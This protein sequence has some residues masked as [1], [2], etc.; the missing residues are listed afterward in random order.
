[1]QYPLQTQQA[2]IAKHGGCGSSKWIVVCTGTSEVR[3]MELLVISFTMLCIN[4]FLEPTVFSSSVTE[5]SSPSAC[6]K[7][8]CFH[9]DVFPGDQWMFIMLISLSHHWS[10][11]INQGIMSIPKIAPHG[12]RGHSSSAPCARGGQ[13]WDRW[14]QSPVAEAREKRWK[15]IWILAESQCT[16][17]EHNL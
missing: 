1:M 4:P 7:R 6:G 12:C 8:N 5:A 14:L 16:W 9:C 17:K 15:H 11:G 13:A 10:L 2:D 3:T